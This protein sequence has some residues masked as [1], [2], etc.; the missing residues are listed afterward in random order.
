MIG[1]EAAKGLLQTRLNAAGLRE[2]LSGSVAPRPAGGGSGA[3]WTFTRQ[4]GPA[5]GGATALAAG[6]TDRHVHADF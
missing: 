3:I 4:A 5:R 2:P 1:P 6:V